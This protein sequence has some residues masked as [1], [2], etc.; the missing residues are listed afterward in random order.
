[1]DLEPVPLIAFAEID[2]TNAEALRRARGGEPGPLWITAQTQTAG[3]G[4]RGRTW[5]SRAGNLFASLLLREP[6]P[7][8]FAP[9]LSF[10]AGLAVHDAVV[11][12]ADTGLPLSLKWPNDMVCN[13]A[14]LAGVL[15][16]GEGSP[17][18][19]VIGIG[20]NCSHHPEA[21]EYPATDL[22]ALGVTVTPEALFDA[23]RRAMAERL[24]QWQRGMGFA[25]IRADWLARA[26][27]VGEPI[28]VRMPGR[29]IEGR[30]SA[31]DEAGRLLIG[32]PGGGCEA[33][34]AGDV[35]P[36]SSAS[37]RPSRPIPS[38]SDRAP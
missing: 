12:H 4:R 5:V 8:A 30:F 9:Q 29:E 1:M 7:A 34:A 14:K 27:G 10:V 20:I 26:C 32:L 38:V 31:L 25:S 23:L 33:I 36:L 2:S 18:V 6:S 15:I 28:R 35:M 37:T 17:L 24:R 19:A 16:E 13:G 3:R 21:T 22:A 11:R